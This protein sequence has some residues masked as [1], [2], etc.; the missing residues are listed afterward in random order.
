MAQPRQL[1]VAPD[2]V[3]HDQLHRLLQ[4]AAQRRGR[5]RPLVG[6]VAHDDHG[7]AD[8]AA[9][10]QRLEDGRAAGE[11]A[12]HQR[13]AVDAH[14]RKHAGHGGGRHQRIHA[15]G[16]IV[17]DALVVASQ[18][19]GDDEQLDTRG[20]DALEVDRAGD[21]LAQR[22]G[23][24]ERSGTI[25]GEE[26]QHAGQ[27]TRQHHRGPQRVDLLA[28]H[29]PPEILEPVETAVGDHRGVERAGAGAGDQ[30][31]RQA[32]LD[33]R[34]GHAR[35]PRPLGPAARQDQGHRC[36]GGAARPLA[37]GRGRGEQAQQRGDDQ[38]KLTTTTAAS[39]RP[40]AAAS[41]QRSRSPSQ[42]QAKAAKT[43]S[44]MTSWATFSCAAV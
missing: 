15:H 25:E 5:A 7:A 22:R 18:I 3:D 42:S 13:D 31:Y 23:I 9:E 29:R 4:R 26:R 8:R 35:L 33:E 24:E 17:E 1:H 40:K 21:Q 30:P 27:Q 38:G 12:V 36:V 37:R 10:R 39:T 16:A 14:G 34:R 2:R 44:V 6:R 19:R 28:R 32:A 11:A 43:T 41:F 20:A